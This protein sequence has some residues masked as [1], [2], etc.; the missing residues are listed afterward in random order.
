MKLKDLFETK[1]WQTPTGNKVVTYF[2]TEQGSKYIL[3]DKNESRRNKSVHANTGGDDKGIHDWNT[4]CIFV[5]PKFE[6]KANSIIMLDGKIGIKN[7][8]IST[9][10]NKLAFYHNGKVLLFKDAFPKTGGEDPLYFE[11]TLT[12]TKG[13]HVVEY[14]LQSDGYSIKSYHFG[15]KVSVVKPMTDELAAKFRE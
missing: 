7:I 12:P 3:S 15:S 6:H 13:F 8:K 14:N 9:K 10:N 11:Y 2:E 5:D 1:N 4:H